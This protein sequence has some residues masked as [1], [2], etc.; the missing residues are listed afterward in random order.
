MDLIQTHESTSWLLVCS[1]GCYQV[2]LSIGLIV[3]SIFLGECISEY[4]IMA[5]GIMIFGVCLV[6]RRDRN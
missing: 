6:S 5:A 2:W 3:V 1:L 4:Q